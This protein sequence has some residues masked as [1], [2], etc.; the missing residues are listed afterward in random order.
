MDLAQLLLGHLAGCAHHQVLRIAVE[1][2]CDD[3]TDGVLLGDQHDHTVNAGCHACVGRCAVGE[4]GVKRTELR[5][6]VLLAVAGDLKRLAH[7]LGVMVTHGTGGKLHAVAHDIVLVSKDLQRILVHEGIHAALGHREGV[8]RKVDLAGL[9]VALV[10]REVHDEAELK[11]VG[12]YKVQLVGDPSAHLSG[13]RVDHVRGIADEEQR[14]ALLDAAKRGQLCLFLGGEELGDRALVVAVLQRDIAA[15][16]LHADAAGVSVDR[17][18]KRLLAVAVAILLDKVVGNDAAYQLVFE[19]DGTTVEL[20]EIV[21]GKEAGQILDLQ[22][23]AQ[24]GLIGAVLEHGVCEGDTAE[25]RL[26]D[27]LVGKLFEGVVHHLLGNAEHVLLRCKG[28]LKVKLIKFSGRA[29]LAGILVAEAGCD[30]EVAVKAG[31]HQQLLE[32]LG[33]LGQRVELA[34]VLAAGYEVITC[35]LGR[36]GGEN[37]GLDL[38][39]A[40]ILHLRAQVGKDLGAQ[41]DI[42]MDLLVAQVKVAVLQAHLLTGEGG[43]VDLK[44]QTELAGTKHLDGCGTYLDQAGGDLGVDGVL[45]TLCDFTLDLHHGF[46]GDAGKQLVVGKYDLCDTV[47]VAQVYKQHAAVVA[48]GIHPTGQ[49]DLAADIFNGQLVTGMRSQH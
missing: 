42:V 49:R 28:H 33:R 24:V 27:L 19:G 23:V 38:Q 37:G 18:F 6:N 16:K 26:G 22:G 4:G 32:L 5:L 35:A 10:H 14:V 39:K 25:G 41:H 29:V 44:G 36:G 9:L 31:C 17:F 47:V 7:D 13:E 2:E 48:D 11:A 43:G 46:L 15:A 21:R 3:V 12:L 8:V 30:L 40:H 1:R 34:L 45:V 20:Q